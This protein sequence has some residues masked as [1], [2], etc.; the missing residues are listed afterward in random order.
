MKQVKNYLL[1]CLAA[2]AVCCLSIDGYAAPRV[3]LSRVRSAC[4]NAAGAAATRAL[5]QLNQVKANVG[6]QA[7]MPPMKVKKSKGKTGLHSTEEIRKLMKMKRPTELKSIKQVKQIQESQNR[8][9]QYLE[10]LCKRP[11]WTEKDSI[12][13]EDIVERYRNQT[14]SPQDH[15]AWRTILRECDTIQP[16]PRTPFYFCEPG[17]E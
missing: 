17:L 13:K 11:V 10:I 12:N 16:E 1:V 5:G 6:Q 3:R 7:Q 2:I 14:F 4:R 8:L 9:Q 15:N